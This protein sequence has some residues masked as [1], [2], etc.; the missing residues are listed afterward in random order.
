[1]GTKKLKGKTLFI[2]GASRGI[3]FAIA[4]RAA[5]DGANIIIAAKTDAPKPGLEG[6]IHSAAAELNALGGHAIA[7]VCDVRNVE[8]IAMAIDA[9]VTAFGG[10]DIV[11][12]NASAIDLSPTA[13]VDP[14][15][16]ALMHDINVRGTFMV[17]RMAL[18]HLIKGENPQVLTLSPPLQHMAKWLAKYPAYASSKY[19]MSMLTQGFAGEFATHGIAVNSLWPETLIATA[20]VAHFPNGLQLLRHSRHPT[21]V[22][23]AAYIILTQNSREHTGQFYVDIDVLRSAGIDD[24]SM[25]AVEPGKE[26]YPDIFLD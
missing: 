13:Q 1:M 22:A 11:V 9:G 24:F 8:Q 16:Y 21:I 2:S 25:Y 4:K 5:Q 14:K 6:T 3:G 17:T 10:I 26:L 15:R 12:N 23:D 19:G 18:Q 7:V 20:A